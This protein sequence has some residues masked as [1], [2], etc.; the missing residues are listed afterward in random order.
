V[1]GESFARERRRTADQ[2]VGRAFVDDP[3]AGVPGARPQIDH[4]V[5][6]AQEVEVVLDDDDRVAPRDQ[7]AESA[8]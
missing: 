2:S 4:P 8:E 5:G 7:R 6:V 1:F 3:S